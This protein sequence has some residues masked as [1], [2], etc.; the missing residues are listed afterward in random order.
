VA[1]DDEGMSVKPL[2]AGR[3]A[4]TRQSAATRV[5][6]ERRRGGTGGVLPA[7]CLGLML[8]M[9][10][11]TLVNVTMPAIGASMHASVTGLQWVADIYTLTYASLLLPGGALGNRLGRR[12]A[13]L[14]GIAVFLVG[15]LL[16]AL[17]PSL[18]VLL[19]ARVVQALGVAVMLPQT[20]AILVHEYAEPAARSR[21][22]G[23]WAGVAS[24]GLAAG[25]VLGGLVITVA[26]WRTG[27]YLTLVL[28][29]VALVLGHRVIP[30][31]RH[32]RPA[33][34]PAVDPLG[35]ALGVLWLGA[36]VYGLIEAG[37]HGWGSPVIVA[38]FAVALAGATAF[39]VTQHRIARRGGRPLMPLHL[40]RAPGF[41]AA[42]AAGLVY[43]FTLF[44]IL[45]YYSL[46]LER[47]QDR[48]P[49][50][51]G[52]L[53]LPM[54][55]CMAA[56]APVAGRLVAR[57]GT[58]AT[59]TG[60]LLIAAAGC[61][62]LA[63]QPDNAGL[64]DLGWRLSLVGIGAGLMSA[65]MSNAAVSSVPAEH[66]GTASAVH[67]TCRQIGASLGIAL[68]GVVLNARQQAALARPSKALGAPARTAVE[69]AARAGRADPGQAAPHL[70]APLRRTIDAAAHAGFTSG[71]HTAMLLTALALLACAA[72][73]A[74]LL[75]PRSGSDHRTP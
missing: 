1:V 2:D 28:A 50:V 74:A 58:R 31:A 62:A 67:N 68:L 18:P 40:W 12:A 35:S 60:G 70:P 30:R 39:V 71:L 24:L 4:A 14:G 8:T 41:V 54:T 73:A 46:S 63:R 72:A 19:A 49:L 15:S 16:C 51:T 69:A 43:F 9:L 38:S 57:V 6:P 11:S 10:N 25:P 17:A 36:L 65:T 48:S 66:S 26:D 3:P 27:F 61:L 53:F 56:L 52:S 20:L 13:F 32:G 22:I 64:P 45:F 23:V 5:A 7:M 34:G 21:A 33:A 44:G 59:L 29:A 37:D 42:N 47:Q 55:V 75:R